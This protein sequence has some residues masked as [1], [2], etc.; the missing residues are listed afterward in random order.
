MEIIVAETRYFGRQ[1]K[2]KSAIVPK[3]EKSSQRVLDTNSPYVL[4]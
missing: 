2:T 4:A 1:V 3:N